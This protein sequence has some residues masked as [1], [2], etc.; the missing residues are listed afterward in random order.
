MGKLQGLALCFTIPP[1]VSRSPCF[2]AGR[3]LTAAGFADCH[4]YQLQRIVTGMGNYSVIISLPMP[5]RGLAPTRTWK[6]S[7][8]TALAGPRGPP[9]LTKA[10]SNRGALAP[11]ATGRGGGFPVAQPRAIA[12]SHTGSTGLPSTKVAAAVPSINTAASRRL[13]PFESK[14]AAG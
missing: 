4:S 11:K 13:S 3:V 6:Q 1:T 12:A 14:M 7:A 2:S 10:S 5:D 8:P 9:H